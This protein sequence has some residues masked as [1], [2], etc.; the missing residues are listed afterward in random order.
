[1]N[2]LET[3]LGTQKA[4]YK[5]KALIYFAEGKFVTKFL[6]ICY[7]TAN[8]LIPLLYNNIALASEAPKSFI[9]G[10]GRSTPIT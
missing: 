9:I 3:C 2:F 1:M 10:C 8:W 5:L 7:K 4:S 6:N